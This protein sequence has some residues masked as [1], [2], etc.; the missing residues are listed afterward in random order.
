MDVN[1]PDIDKF[2]AILTENPR[3]IVTCTV[4]VSET[5]LREPPGQREWPVV[6]ILAHIRACQDLCSFSIYAMLTEIQPVLPGLDERKWVKVTHYA[7]L[8]FKDSFQA[9]LLRR[10]EL[11]NVLRKLSFED[12]SRSAVIGGRTQTIFS[13]VRRIAFQELEH[14]EEIEIQM[15]WKNG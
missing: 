2:L 14:V 10:I 9:F 3:R 1:Q 6:E 12:W 4:G 11:I 7:A 8:P 5:T 13:Q 15:G